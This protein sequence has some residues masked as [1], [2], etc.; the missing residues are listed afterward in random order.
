MTS[1]FNLLRRMIAGALMGA[2]LW[3]DWRRAVLNGW[4][5]PEC[6]RCAWWVDGT[7]PRTCMRGAR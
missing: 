6:A 4:A 1:L 3:A 2:M 7:C 5:R